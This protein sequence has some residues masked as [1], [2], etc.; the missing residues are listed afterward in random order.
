MAD[1]P[2]VPRMSRWR[3]QGWRVHSA[4]STQ[5]R[6]KSPGERASKGFQEVPLGWALREFPSTGYSSMWKLMA[7]RYDPGRRQS[8]LELPEPRSEQRRRRASGRWG[9]RLLQHQIRLGFP[10]QA[11]FYFPLI[12]SGKRMEWLW[13]CVCALIEELKVGAWE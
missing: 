9:W 11:T 12:F 3:L 4:K 6:D 5:R 10:C 1:V 8:N 7:E 13:V 2:K